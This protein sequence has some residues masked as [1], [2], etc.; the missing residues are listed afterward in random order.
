[1]EATERAAPSGSAVF[2]YKSGIYRAAI[3]TDVLRSN[4]TT[5]GLRLYRLG[6]LLADVFLGRVF[7][8]LDTYFDWELATLI[9]RRGR[10][11]FYQLYPQF[12][13]AIKID[14]AG[15]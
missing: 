7:G 12:L 5:Q 15:T 2:D 1:L 14:N 10:P 3:G 4:G 8:R 6:E 9:L 11:D 13:T